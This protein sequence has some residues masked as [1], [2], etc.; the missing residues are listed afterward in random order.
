MN[1]CLFKLWDNASLEKWTK[2]RKKGFV[3]FLITFGFG[4]VGSASFL[5]FFLG[6]SVSMVLNKEPLSFVKLFIAAVTS[7]LI[8]AVYAWYYWK[9][10]EESYLQITSK[11]KEDD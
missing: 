2:I 4:V 6:F 5:I 11:R 9:G 10:T 8:G 3:A 1:Y 7:G